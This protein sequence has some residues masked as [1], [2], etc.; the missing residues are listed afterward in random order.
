MTDLFVNC[1]N[2]SFV[3]FEGCVAV[4]FS[5]Q[6]YQY[7]TFYFQFAGTTWSNSGIRHWICQCG[8][9]A[10]TWGLFNNFFLEGGC[11]VGIYTILFR[12]VYFLDDRIITHSYGHWNVTS[13]HLKYKLRKEIG[14]NDSNDKDFA[15]SIC[16]YLLDPAAGV[17]SCFFS[18]SK[19]TRFI[20]YC[21]P[22]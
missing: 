15:A 21:R 17:H 5:N 6:Q 1:I 22:K 13:T 18:P 11:F 19:A 20:S 9:Q 3:H 2:C 10:G 14:S 4:R 12:L 7:Y 16:N 8:R